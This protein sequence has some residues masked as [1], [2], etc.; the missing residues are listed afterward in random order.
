LRVRILNP[1]PLAL[2]IILFDKL[3]VGFEGVGTT[4]PFSIHGLGLG[5]GLGFGAGWALRR[6]DGWC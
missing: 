2:R 5:L 4:A 1:S 3:G 6:S